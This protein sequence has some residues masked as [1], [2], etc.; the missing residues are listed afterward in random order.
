MVEVIK[1]HKKITCD[2]C[3]ARLPVKNAPF[4]LDGA[5]IIKVKM[6]YEHAFDKCSNWKNVR[7]D[8][9]PNCKCGMYHWIE[10]YKEKKE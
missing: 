3:G 7:L 4:P 8:L 6:S 1:R 5:Y 10:R 9:C 2:I